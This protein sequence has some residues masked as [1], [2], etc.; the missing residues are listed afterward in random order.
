MT[1]KATHEWLYAYFF[2]KRFGPSAD[3]T[4]IYTSES[5]IIYEWVLDEN[6][7]VIETLAGFDADIGDYFYVYTVNF[8]EDKL[9]GTPYRTGSMRIYGI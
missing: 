8:Y 4:E 2:G 3:F 7:E 6:V 5:T 9:S 1:E